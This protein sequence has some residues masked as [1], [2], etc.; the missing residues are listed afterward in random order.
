MQIVQWIELEE[1]RE[2]S[3]VKSF[4]MLAQAQVGCSR[5][6]SLD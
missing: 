3:A 2:N 4:A 6:E 1:A 5:M